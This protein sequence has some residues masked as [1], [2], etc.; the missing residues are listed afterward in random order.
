MTSPAA[1]DRLEIEVQDFG[2]IVHAKLDLRPMTVFVGPSNTGKSYLAILLYALHR[3]FTGIGTSGLLRFGRMHPWDLDREPREFPADAVAD[4]EQLAQ[5]IDNINSMERGRAIALPDG[6]IKSIRS[7]FSDLGSGAGAEVLRCFGMDE[8]ATLI[9]KG[10]GNRARL[11]VRRGTANNPHS[12]EHYL[13]FSSHGAEFQTR[14]PDSISLPSALLAEIGAD[15]TLRY[16]RARAS[17][18]VKDSD[19][20]PYWDIVDWLIEQ[21]IPYLVG[22]LYLP[23]FYLPADRTGVVHAHSALVSAMIDN[24]PMAGLR[25]AMRTPMFS[26]VLADFLR[27]IIQVDSRRPRR[28]DDITREAPRDVSRQIERNILRGAVGVE[29]SELINYPN[30][31]YRPDGW[32]EDLPLMHASSMVSELAPVVLYLRHLVRPGNVLIIEEPESHLH[33]AAQV[34]FTRQLAKLVQQGYRVIITTHS[35][36]ILEELANVVQRSQLPPEELATVSESDAALTAD[37]VGVWLFRP[38][39]RPRGSEVVHVSLGDSGLYDAGFDDV[40]I[41]LSNDGANIF[42]R[43]GQN[44]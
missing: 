21:I 43:I 4:F 23:A 14:I 25:P 9:R 26:G 8:V 19:G 38:K 40:A 24:V 33:P 10:H 30:F 16:I 41:A 18:S 2:P 7:R 39:R 32:K 22:G 11:I 34:E 3:S 42:N 15:S 36:W 28:P 37:Q 13:E 1:N 12:S 5:D 44:E 6:I 35:E 20:F 29:R 17:Q 31:T 27:D